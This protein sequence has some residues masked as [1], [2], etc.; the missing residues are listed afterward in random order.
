MSLRKLCL[1]TMLATA[2]AFAAAEGVNR[3]IKKSGVRKTG[4]PET[5]V[6]A[7]KTS[8]GASTFT[9]GFPAESQVLPRAWEPESCW[10]RAGIWAI[11]ASPKP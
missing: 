8:P 4:V 11:R 3:Y 7:T 6:P 10:W 1:Y 2:L 5:G 9:T